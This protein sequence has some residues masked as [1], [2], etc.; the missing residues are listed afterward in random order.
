MEGNRLVVGDPVLQR[1][2][3][4]VSYSVGICVIAHDFCDVE[5]VGVAEPELFQTHHVLF[6][7]A[8]WA[9]SELQGIVEHGDAFVCYPGGLVIVLDASGEI[10]ISQQPAKTA[11]VMGQSVVA[12]VFL[13]YDQRN[14]LTLHLAESFRP[15]HGLAIEDVVGVHTPGVESVDPQD[16]IDPLVDRV[17][18]FIFQ[19]LQII[20]PLVFVR[21]FDPGHQR[22]LVVHRKEDH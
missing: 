21:G 5:N 14:H 15:F 7:D 1:D 9:D 12:V 10:I 22:N 3:Q 4:T 19:A 18:D 11:P 20:A 16:P 8:A 2:A 6:C 13:G 17:D